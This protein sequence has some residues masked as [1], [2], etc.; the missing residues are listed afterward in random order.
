MHLVKVVFNKTL[1]WYE[2][3][4]NLGL[5]IMCCHPQQDLIS[6]GFTKDSLMPRPPAQCRK[7]DL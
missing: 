1:Y 7:I 3:L 2:G 4:R 6:R 5:L